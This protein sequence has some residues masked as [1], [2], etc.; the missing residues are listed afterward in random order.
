MSPTHEVLNQPPPLVDWNM[1][2]SDSVLQSSVQLFGAGWATDPLTQFG[3]LMGS[4]DVIQYGF[5]ANLNLPVLKTHDRF[6]N[7]VDEVVFHPHYHKLMEHSVANGVHTGPWSDPQPGA[8]VARAAMMM[9]DNANEFGHCCPISMT[10]AVVPALKKQPE[11]FAVWKEK[12]FSKEYDPR[13]LPFDQK[14]GVIMGMAMT[15]KQGGSDV[16]ANT[17]QAIPLSHTTGPGAEYLITGHKFFCSAPMSDAFLIL[18]Q[19]SKGLS[20]F[21]VSRFKPD[22]TKNNFFIQRL[23]DK[24]GNR[25]NASSEIELENTWAVMVGEEGR[26]VPTI[27]DMVN[28]T[29][30]DCVIGATGMLRHSLVQA[31]HHSRHRQAFGKKLVDQVLMKNTLADLALESEAATWLMM[32]LAKAYDHNHLPAECA[33]RRIATAIAKYYITKRAPMAAT[34]ALECLGGS[35][36][37][38]ESITARIYR[39]IP[40]NSIW[41]GSGS[42]MALDVLRA[43]KREEGT[44]EAIQN[45]LAVD[46]TEEYRRFVSRTL[47]TLQSA[48]DLETNARRLVEQLA[49]SLQAALMFKH[50]LP[51]IA[52]IFCQSRLTEK[53][54]S[55]FGTLEST[56]D[57][58]L[59]ISR[60]F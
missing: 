14:K 12:L 56:T 4:R 50:S 47:Q 44:L 46:G 7:R 20:C 58:D 27:V 1:F 54:T 32:R 45:E 42:V 25:S 10:Y 30:L 22:G 9:M 48:T 51:K 11:I 34:E 57:F 16:R 29:R 33:F 35:G 24:L 52:E 21:L 60:A 39:D 59:I 40:L 8:H 41:E 3:Q 26:G 49:L 38:E 36:Y 15:E 23:K 2:S 6:G 5:D 55:T 28:H 53:R 18:A 31:I 37:V 13:F 43:L 17:T 19:T